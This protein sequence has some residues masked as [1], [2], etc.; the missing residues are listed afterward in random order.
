MK[1]TS[2]VVF[3]VVL[4]IMFLL[5]AC[6]KAAPEPVAPVATETVVCQPVAQP[7]E[8][9]GYTLDEFLNKFGT[10]LVPAFR[11]VSF[12][13]NSESMNV[14]YNNMEMVLVNTF[15][16]AH[17][18]VGKATGNEMAFEEM[19]LFSQKFFDSVEGKNLVI[20]RSSNTI[21]SQTTLVV[22]PEEDMPKTANLSDWDKTN[23]EFTVW[24]YPVNTGFEVV[25]STATGEILIVPFVL[26][27]NEQGHDS[28]VQPGRQM[29]A[30]VHF[31][32]DANG[33][34]V[35]RVD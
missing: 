33:H 7:T 14:V 21:T 2:F 32:P 27:K 15:L 20:F 26:E 5:T 9:A 35:M 1:K 34:L 31:D 10:S 12:D 19:A 18:F 28:V 6:A 4:V 29:S 25:Q 8:V 16:N 24:A 17:V 22:I 13:Q 3:T 11:V 23:M 30:Y